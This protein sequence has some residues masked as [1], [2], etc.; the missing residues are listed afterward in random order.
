MKGYRT[1][2]ADGQILVYKYKMK[3]TESQ[4]SE[5]S[6]Q[7]VVYVEEEREEEKAEEEEVGQPINLLLR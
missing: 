7:H 2:R 5:A 6:R 1:G 3:N 4:I